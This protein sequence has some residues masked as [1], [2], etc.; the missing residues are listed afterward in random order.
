MY[1]EYALISALSEV[2]ISKELSGIE[3]LWEPDDKYSSR[4]AL[5]TAA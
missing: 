3:G 1:A 4:R 2:N 5:C